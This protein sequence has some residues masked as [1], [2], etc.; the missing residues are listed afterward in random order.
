MIFRSDCSSA[1]CNKGVGNRRVLVESFEYPDHGFHAFLKR[2]SEGVERAAVGQFPHA[3][4][5]H[6]ANLICGPELHQAPQRIPAELPHEAPLGSGEHAR[7]VSHHAFFPGDDVV[8]LL[9]RLRSLANARFRA[10][11]PQFPQ[12]RQSRIPVQPVPN[13]PAPDERPGPA[14]AAPA[15]Q[16]DPFAPSQ[17]RVDLVEDVACRGLGQGSAHVRDLEGVVLGLRVELPKDVPVGEQA[18]EGRGQVDENTNTGGGQGL[19]LGYGRFVVVVARVFA[20]QESAG[21]D[22]VGVQNRGGRHCLVLCDEVVEGALRA[23]FSREGRKTLCS[24]L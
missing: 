21:D 24:R 3:F 5:V 14:H 1:C 7:F 13:Q 16:I 19:Q 10:P 12:L 18:V 9:L 2:S 17:G 4:R 6:L 22:P 11:R 23:M 20:G 15:V 8:P